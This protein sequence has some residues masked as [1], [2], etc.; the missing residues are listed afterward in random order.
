MI[1]ALQSLARSVFLRLEALL[2]RACGED[3]NPLYHLGAISF[4]LFWLIAASGL[5]LYVFF[6]TSVAGAYASVQRLTEVQWYAGGILRSLH[7]YAADAMV[8]CMG[9]HLARHFA[10]D[11][12]RGFRSFSWLTGVALIWLVLAAGINGYMLPWDRLAQ[13]VVV[14]TFEW[15]DGLPLFGGVLIRNFISAASVNDRL[16]SLLS[17]IH[18][19]APLLVLLLMWIHVQRVPKASTLPPRPMAAALLLCLLALALV[20][21]ALSQGGVADLG[22]VF[23]PLDF[24]WFYLA[25]FALL[26]LWPVGRVWALVGGATALLAALP[27]LPPQRRRVQGEWQVLLQ[28][29]QRRIPVRRGE[30]VLEAGL[31]AGVALPYECRNGG[32]GKCLCQIISGSVD[33]GTYQH[34]ALSAAQKAQGAALMCCAVPLC[35]LEISYARAENALQSATPTYSGRVVDMQRLAEDVMRLD[36]ILS[37]GETLQF[38]AGQYINIDCD[39]GRPRAY[40]FANAP[41]ARGAI[42]LHVRRVPGG[43]FTGAVFTTLRVGDTLRFAGPYGDFTLRDG[44]R[45]IILVAGATGFAP[46]KSIIEEA[47]Q[48]GLQRPMLLYWG[49]RQR[50]D[51]YMA[52]LAES[53]QQQHPNFRF[54]P[55][56]SEPAAEDDWHGRSGPVHAAILADLPDLTGYEAYVCGSVNMVDAAFPDFLK[57]GLSED[58]CFSDAFQRAPATAR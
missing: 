34:S 38:K 55:V 52:E 48:R 5:Y 22:T 29:E 44:T 39:D 40:S 37:K 13:F 23:S 50:K 58:S 54:L 15:L 1:A 4:G 28:G 46:L 36:I 53:W 45:P 21:P 31:R 17:F 7:R 42:E 32:C 11:K 51:L 25:V 18:I 27:W 49:V 33:A 26:Y 20:K 3:L 57:H 47:W 6:E 8:L 43:R 41:N 30:T 12:L 2:N 16:F 35:D 19:G 14:A 24:D 56:L 10:F 9:L